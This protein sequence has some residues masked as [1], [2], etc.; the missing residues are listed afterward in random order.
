[1]KRKEIALNR[2]HSYP[3]LSKKALLPVNAILV[4]FFILVFSEGKAAADIYQY[5]DKNGHWVLTDSPPD[6][7]EKMEIRKDKDARSSRSSGFRDIEKDLTE[8]Y[9][10]K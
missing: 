1:M 8:K 6:N 5:K 9:R 4:L 2:G 7:V 3:Y 10:P